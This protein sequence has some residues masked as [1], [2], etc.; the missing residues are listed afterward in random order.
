MIINENKLMDGRMLIP[1]LRVIAPELPEDMLLH[2]IRQS[3][4]EFA[5]RSQ[6]VVQEHCIEVQPCVAEYEI[7][8]TDNEQFV[9]F[10]DTTVNDGCPSI[11]GCSDKRPCE[12]TECNGYVISW[13]APRQRLML[14]PEPSKASK[15]Y[16]KIAV[17]PSLTACEF[18]PRLVADN[19]RGVLYGALT[20]LHAIP[21]TQTKKKKVCKNRFDSSMISYYEHK[22]QRE[23]TAAGIDRLLNQ[24]RGLVKMKKPRIM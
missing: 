16:L 11:K 21:P 7:Y 4:I 20:A 3:A 10:Q 9:S 15:L 19:Y 18:D 24:K 5:K 2:Y 22:F 1:E 23:I 14:S 12:E 6:V 8:L 17:A 13:S